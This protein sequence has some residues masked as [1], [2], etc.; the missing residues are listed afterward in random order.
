MERQTS[1]DDR[2]V[3]LH[4]LTCGGCRDEVAGGPDGFIKCVGEPVEVAR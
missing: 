1:T 4:E 2:L 3:E